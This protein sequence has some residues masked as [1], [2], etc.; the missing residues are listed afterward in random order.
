MIFNLSDASSKMVWVLVEQTKSGTTG[1]RDGQSR[2]NSGQLVLP[3]SFLVTC[4]KC[5]NKKCHSFKLDFKWNAIS[6]WKWLF[7][8][9]TKETKNVVSSAIPSKIKHKIVE[10]YIIT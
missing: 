5:A 2:Q 9:A 8:L 1:S 6:S 10:Q 3:C 7:T 4:P